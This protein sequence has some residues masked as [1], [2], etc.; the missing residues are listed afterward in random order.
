VPPRPPQRD[1]FDLWFK[2]KQLDDGD[3]NRWRKA[4]FDAM[5]GARD[6]D[7]DPLGPLE[8]RALPPRELRYERN[9]VP[10]DSSYRK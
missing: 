3:L 6:W 4:V 2:E 10:Q 9:E 5:N 8:I 7:S 1:A